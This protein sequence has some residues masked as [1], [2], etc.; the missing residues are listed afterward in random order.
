VKARDY[1]ENPG[2]DAILMKILE[3]WGRK[4]FSLKIVKTAI[5]LWTS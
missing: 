5:K 3:K 1:L 4:A 2:T